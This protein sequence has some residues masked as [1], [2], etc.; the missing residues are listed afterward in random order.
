MNFATMLLIPF[1]LLF[2]LLYQAAPEQ[3][4]ENIDKMFIEINEG[5]EEKYEINFNSQQATLET[6]IFLFIKSAVLSM[7]A[8]AVLVAWLAAIIPISAELLVVIYIAFFMIG[9]IPWDLLLGTG[10]L[11]NDWWKKRRKKNEPNRPSE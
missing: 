6:T 1:F 8:L 10:L 5:F 4:Y 2:L 9:N 3:Y 11:V 7:F